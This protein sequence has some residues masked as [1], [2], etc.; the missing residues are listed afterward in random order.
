[1]HF[2]LRRTAKVMFSPLFVWLCLLATLR[3]NSWTG[4]H[5][6]FRIDR[7]WLKKPC[8]IL[9]DV[10]SN[11]LHTG[12]VFFRGI[13]VC[14]QLYGKT[15]EQIFMKFSRQV[16]Y[17][18]KNNL[19]QFGDV[20]FNRLDRGSMF[21]FAGSVLARATLREKNGW[22]DFHGNFRMCWIQHNNIINVLARLFH[23]QIILF[24]VPQTW[25][26]VMSVK[27]NF[28]YSNFFNKKH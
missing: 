19:H 14:E 5:E 28:I 26:G 1:M 13:R 22:T 2:Y 25:H 9:G 11:P 3:A 24:H 18:T 20:A 8:E 21:I 10:S 12:I 6:S 16:R 4:F 27:V 17:K 7:I 15:G 23:T